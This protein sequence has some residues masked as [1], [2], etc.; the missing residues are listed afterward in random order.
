MML[1]IKSPSELSG[2]QAALVEGMEQTRYGVKLSLPSKLQAAAQLARL[3]G[4][5][6]PAKVAATDPSGKESVPRNFSDAE[7]LAILNACTANAEEAA[8]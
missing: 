6:A 7:L 1:R 3:D 8:K 5:D 4:L 2:E